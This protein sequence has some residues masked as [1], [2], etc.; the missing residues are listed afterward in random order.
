MVQEIFYT[1]SGFNAST[2]FI[3]FLQFFQNSV[4]AFIHTLHKRF[5]LDVTARL[6]IPTES[7]KI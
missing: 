7:L 3:Y 6:A 1:K 4:L 2:F 5:S